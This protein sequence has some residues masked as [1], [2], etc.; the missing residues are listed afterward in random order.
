MPKSKPRRIVIQQTQGVT[1]RVTVEVR[2]VDVCDQHAWAVAWLDKFR[3]YPTR[4]RAVDAGSLLVTRLLVCGITSELVIR[5]V[6]GTVGERRTY[7]DDPERS[8]G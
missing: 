6:N 5:R 7:G 8:R 4:K 3:V 1:L 2:P